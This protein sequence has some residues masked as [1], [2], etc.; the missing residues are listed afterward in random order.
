MRRIFE[1]FDR[2]YIINLR[3]RTDRRRAVEKEFKRIG[4]EIPN[5]KIRFYTS[6]SPTEQKRFPTLGAR[7][8]FASHRAV[9]DLALKESL[10][11]VLIIEDDIFL[12]PAKEDHL[13]DLVHQLNNIDWDIVYFG[14]LEPVKPESA[15]PLVKWEGA[16]L[17]GH[18]YAVNQ[19]YMYKMAKY[20]HECEARPP[21]HPLGGPMFRDGAYNHLRNIDENI[22]VFLA[23][24]TLAKQRSTR[25][26][27]HALSLF[28][29]LGWLRPLVKGSR[30]IKNFLRRFVM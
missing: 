10:N 30:E 12:M 15:R 25:T 24:P 14:Y 18:F 26:D 22:K 7:G 2:T 16:T 4:I 19:K 27:L 17:G 13:T 29:R 21:G 23:V 5:D 1:N 28:D 6:D 9:L 20:M 3:E 8:S 11:N